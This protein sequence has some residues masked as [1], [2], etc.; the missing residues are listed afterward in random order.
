MTKTFSSSLARSEMIIIVGL[1][2]NMFD[3]G[4]QKCLLIPDHIWTKIK[5]CEMQFARFRNK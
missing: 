4:K 3:C 5:L 1:W 2:Q